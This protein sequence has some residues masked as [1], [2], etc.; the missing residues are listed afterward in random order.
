MPI[1][2]TS[3]QSSQDTG[4]YNPE[5]YSD[6]GGGVPI[7]WTPAYTNTY[8]WLDASDSTTLTQTSGFLSQWDDKSGNARHFTQTVS[9]SQPAVT[10]SGLNNY[11]VISFDGTNDRLNSNAPASAWQFL[12]SSIRSSIYIVLQHTHTDTAGIVFNTNAGTS[13]RTG[14]TYF[15]EDRTIVP[16]SD[17]LAIYCTRAGGF[18]VFYGRI[19]DNSLP[20]GSPCIYSAI[21]NPTATLANRV[22][23]R[24]NGSGVAFVDTS[25]NS[26][27][28][29][30]NPTD[31]LYI[32]ASSTSTTGLPFFGFI[33]ETIICSGANTLS[34]SEKFEGYLAHKWGLTSS[35]PSGHPYRNSPPYV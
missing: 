24:V 6:V 15:I 23:N 20:S 17:S 26:S 18:T 11:D 8:L 5:V 31:T 22:A 1:R 25:S 21:T 33:A 3:N 10:V 14:I 4:F 30:N 29:A 28:T 35:L 13:S 2:R 32:G 9:A 16:A 19:P 34:D 7:P 12:H 27:A